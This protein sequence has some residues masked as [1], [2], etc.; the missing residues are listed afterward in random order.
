M[1]TSDQINYANDI[2][3]YLDKILVSLYDLQG[4]MNRMTD[5]TEDVRDN[6]AQLNQKDKT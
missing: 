6:L 4:G 5:L 2:I 1:K 3:Q